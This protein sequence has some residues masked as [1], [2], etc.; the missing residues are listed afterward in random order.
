MLG[1]II[2]REIQEY[3][4]SKKFL[5]GL[6]ITVALIVLSTIINVRDYARRQQEYLT[7]S[8]KKE[9]IMP[10]IYRP[11]QVLSVLARGKDTKFGNLIT[12]IP[13]S[14]EATTNGYMDRALSHSKRLKSG[15]TAIDY[16]FVV[17]VVLSL[18]VI[19]FGYSSISGE[20]ASG[21]LKQVFSNS[22]ARDK[23]LVGK[24]IGGL[25]VIIISLVIAT[26]IT[27]IIIQFHSAVKLNTSDWIR[28]ILM[29]GVSALYLTVFYTLSMFISVTI[30][31]PSTAL[32][33]LMQIW[34]FLLFIYPSVGV[35]IAKKWYH[36][37][38]EKEIRLH[39]GQIAKNIYG[40]YGGSRIIQFDSKIHEK[41]EDIPLGEYAIS[42]Y[43]IERNFENALNSQ[44]EFS[45][46]ITF[47]SPA[48]LYDRIMERLARTG[49]A[50]LEMFFSNVLPYFRTLYR[51]NLFF[52]QTITPGG[53]ISSG[54]T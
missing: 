49:T 33:V 12:L 3:I 52:S 5:I 10:R 30:S 13:G 47:V 35:C 48:V 44:S 53:I 36:V 15:L 6:F 7:V 1:T 38:S 17:K 37:P 29:L 4:K 14:I 26:L 32:M 34:L 23:L 31:R 24:F 54:G 40:K 41:V 27:L 19:F 28:I 18:M 25:I 21:S 51:E 42:K 39:I 16:N 11:P 45:Q 9:S 8:Q 43:N 2:V 46:K 20:K 50:E 22:L